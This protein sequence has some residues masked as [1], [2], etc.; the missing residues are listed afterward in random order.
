MLHK[1]IVPYLLTHLLQVSTVELVHTHDDMMTPARNITSRCNCST[2]RLG[3]ESIRQWFWSIL[4][5]LNTWQL[6]IMEK[7]LMIEHIFISPTGP[8]KITKVILN[9][10]K[11]NYSEATNKSLREEIIPCQLR[12]NCA[13]L[14]CIFIQLQISRKHSSKESSTCCLRHPFYNSDVFSFNF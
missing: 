7:L 9:I 11:P 8:E 3:R 2:E 13:V 4:P 1:D 6:N 5:L 14:S 12:S 10:K